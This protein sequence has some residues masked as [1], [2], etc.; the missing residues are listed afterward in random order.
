MQKKARAWATVGVMAAGV[1]AGGAG[2][3]AMGLV[4]QQP[5]K[6]DVKASGAGAW[7]V[8]SVHSNVVYR[9]SHLGASS[10]YGVFFNPT[11]SLNLDPANPA[12]ASMEITLPLS[13]LTSGDAKRDQHLRSPD[14]FSAEEFPTITFKSTGFTSA[15]ENAFDVTGDLTLLGKAK[16]VTARL[17]IVGK[18]KGMGGG[19]VMGVEA[20][21]T[22]KR[23]D[24]GMTKYV[25]EGAL[26]DEVKL[27][28]AL[29]TNRK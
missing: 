15:G 24:W 25:K 10:H 12:G 4:A 21:F 1:L 27:I 13:G 7:K 28:A 23:S 19:E 16:P 26:G 9:I 3:G 14:F 17:T 2:L 29:E 6:S 20:T 18:G 5:A 11:G 8:D 22:I